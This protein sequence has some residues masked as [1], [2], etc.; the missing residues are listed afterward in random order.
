MLNDYVNK[1]V[2]DRVC[3]NKDYPT[4]EWIT[5]HLTVDGNTTLYKEVNVNNIPDGL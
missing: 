3:K 1:D 2:G 4:N 5:N